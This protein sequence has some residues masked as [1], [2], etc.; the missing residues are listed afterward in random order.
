MDERQRAALAVESNLV[1]EPSFVGH[2][3]Y[4]AADLPGESVVIGVISFS[5]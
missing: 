1:A 4:R 2:D 5:P 3:A